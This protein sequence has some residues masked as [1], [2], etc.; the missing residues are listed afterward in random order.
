MEKIIFLPIETESRELDAK[1]VLASQ[2]IKQGIS[3][4]IG[5]HNVLNEIAPLFNGGIYIGKNIFLDAMKSNN[6]IY[7]MYKIN[8]FSIL[9]YHEEGAI[10]GGDE[11]KWKLVLKELLEPDR[12]SDDDVILCWGDFQKEFFSKTTTNAQMHVVGG[13][14]LDIKEGSLL[15]KLIKNQSRVKEDNFILINT[16]FTA[17]NHYLKDAVAY[18]QQQI[19]S[20]ADKVNKHRLLVEYADDV[21]RMGFF[22]EMISYLLM[23]NP[24]MNFVLRPHPT[25]SIEFWENVFYGFDNIKIINKYSA[26]EWMERCS[27][28]IQSG[29]TTAFE[30]YFLDKPIINYY[31]VE[32]S[33]T[34]DLTEG[35]SILCKTPHEVHEII[36]G[37]KNKEIIAYDNALLGSLI[38]NFKTDISTIKK[39]GEI[40]KESLADKNKNNINY[41]KIRYLL[42]KIDMKNYLKQYPRYLFKDKLDAYRMA[43]SHFPGFKF[44]EIDSKVKYINNINEVNMSLNFI[45]KDLF[46]LS[47]RK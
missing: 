40:A 16:N 11:T 2:L 3:C 39:I 27:Y 34:I 43:L 17:G 36:N 12:L 26:V 9:W 8:D 10:Y 38:S 20:N 15:R 35:L 5:Q 22:S 31:P 29:C 25:E 28:I 42:K 32:L 21:K 6:D 33:N 47:S 18:K 24:D 44:E 19:D 7:D 23:K 30:A 1:I 14:R 46:I 45:N 37:T 41:L 13:Y 4:F